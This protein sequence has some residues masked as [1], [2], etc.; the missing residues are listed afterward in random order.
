MSK[1]WAVY[2]VTVN[3]GKEALSAVCEQREWEVLE[4]TRPGRQRLIKDGIESEAEAEK[5]AR[6]RAGDSFKS[7]ALFGQPVASNAN[8][9]I[10]PPRSAASSGWPGLF[11]S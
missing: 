7:P 10:G 2:Q 4:R 1:R 5:L 9:R 11:S 3:D 8:G 6:G